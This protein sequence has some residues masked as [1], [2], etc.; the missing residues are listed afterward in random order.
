MTSTFKPQVLHRL[1]CIKLLR[2]AFLVLVM[3]TSFGCDN[4]KRAIELNEDSILKAERRSIEILTEAGCRVTETD[5]DLVGTSGILVTLFPEHLTENGNLLPAVLRELRD[6]RRCFLVLDGT[7]VSQ[8]GLAELRTL[9]NLL[10]LSVQFTKIGEKELQQI[11][12]IVS[13]RL[14]RLSRTRV[15]DD[16]LRHITRL[17]ELVMLYLSHNEITDQGIEHIVELRRLKALKLSETKIEDPSIVRL[18]ELVDL[19][20]LGLDQT[21]IS[22][23]CVPYLARLKKL[24]YLNLSGTKVTPEGLTKLKTSLPDCFIAQELTLEANTGELARKNAG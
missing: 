16:S 18:S 20:Y 17:P 14:L 1:P 19:E 8:T 9:S 2:G 11:E 12:G 13:L 21:Q 3:S 24:K 4:S 10:L 5:D 22:D 7:P 15:N 23:A 6:L